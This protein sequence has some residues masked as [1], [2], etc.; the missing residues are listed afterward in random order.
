MPDFLKACSSC[1]S[2]ERY[3]VNFNQDTDLLSHI[4]FWWI[5]CYTKVGQGSTHQQKAIKLF[6][7]RY[8]INKSI[9][10][11]GMGARS[12]YQLSNSKK[13]SPAFSAAPYRWSHF[14]KLSQA[15]PPMSWEQKMLYRLPDN[16]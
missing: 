15:S 13:H 11:T 9:S 10:Y 6:L 4:D 14:P 5:H 2:S 7:Y 1:I 8:N 3:S 16:K 12:N